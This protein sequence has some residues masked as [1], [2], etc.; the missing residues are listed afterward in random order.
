M[1]IRIGQIYALVFHLQSLSTF[2]CSFFCVHTV[3]FPLLK[4]FFL[5]FSWLLRPSILWVIRLYRE[6]ILLKMC[7]W[8]FFYF[9][10]MCANVQ[11]SVMDVYKGFIMYIELHTFHGSGT[12][13]RQLKYLLN[14]CSYVLYIFH[15]SF[16]EGSSKVS[17]FSLLSWENEKKISFNLP[18]L[19]V[20]TVA[21]LA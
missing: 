18:T 8:I 12:I 6:I 10:C 1:W 7:Y 16:K 9:L 19:R 15:S 17:S 14:S 3:D 21:T 20:G 4:F 13:C 11:T 5:G 2:L